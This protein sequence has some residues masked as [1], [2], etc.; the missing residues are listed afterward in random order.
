MTDTGVLPLNAGV[1]D[2]QLVIV[3]HPDSADR[4]PGADPLDVRDVVDWLEPQLNLDLEKLRVEVH[5]QLPR[6]LPGLEGWTVAG[7]E[8]GA[9]CSA[10]VGIIRRGRF[11]SNFDPGFQRLL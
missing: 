9:C 8:D 10:P 7:G 2:A 11:T 3:S 6:L 1:P 4:P 5:R